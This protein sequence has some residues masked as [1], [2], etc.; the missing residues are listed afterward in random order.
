M[1]LGS[2]VDVVV[3]VDECL[4]VGIVSASGV[5]QN[6]VVKEGVGCGANL[7]CDAV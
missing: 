3:G 6:P 2:V 5:E 1:F 4:D 7:A